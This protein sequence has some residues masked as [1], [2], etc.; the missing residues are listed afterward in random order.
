MSNNVKFARQLNP[1]MNK[2]NDET[3]YIESNKVE[4]KKLRT[5]TLSR[6]VND[7]DTGE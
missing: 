3:R 6:N 7:Y 5:L 4:T 1:R 2:E